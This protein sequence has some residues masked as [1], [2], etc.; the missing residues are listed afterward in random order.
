MT[1]HKPDRPTFPTQATDRAIVWLA[2]LAICG[3]Y[4]WAWSVWG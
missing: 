2:I 1:Y 3:G 4:A